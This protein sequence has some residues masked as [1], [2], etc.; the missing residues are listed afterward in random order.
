[1][2]MYTATF[3]RTATGDAP[4]TVALSAS[5]LSSLS[6]LPSSV[7]ALSSVSIPAS[8]MQLGRDAD[9]PPFCEG[10][11]SAT[12]TE[13]CETVDVS[14]RSNI[15]GTGGAPG[16]RVSLAGYVTK[17][18]EIECHDPDGLT[19]SLNAAGSGFSIMSV[20]ENIGIEGAVTFN[21]T[22]KEL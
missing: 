6:S 11:I 4:A 21:V 22:V 14:N 19:A 2:A 5:T 16:R 10:I 9:A 18:W 13:E 7:T 8:S 20:S 3:T 1:M 15:G 12:Y 17:T